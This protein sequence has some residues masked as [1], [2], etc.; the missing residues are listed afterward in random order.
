MA[1]VETP[2]ESEVVSNGLTNE[3][4]TLGRANWFGFTLLGFLVLVLAVMMIQA[5]DKTIEN[6]K[7]AADTESTAHNLARSERESLIFVVSFERWLNGSITLRELQIRRAFLA[8]RL[9][10]SDVEGISNGTRASVGYMK[11]LRALDDYMKLAEPG[12]LSPD[13]QIDL[14]AKSESAL[15]NFVFETNKL[16]SIVSM[17]SDERINQLVRIANSNR[18]NSSGAIL[19]VLILVFTVAGSLLVVRLRYFRR[20]QFLIEHDRQKNEERDSVLRRVEHELQS[21]LEKERMDRSDQEWIDA[22]TRSI[23]S[24]FKS[25]LIPERVAELLGEELGRVLG[26][27]TVLSL[28]LDESHLSKFLTQWNQNPKIEFKES[29]L[30]QHGSDL[31]ALAS[32]IWRDKRVVTVN[33]S[34]LIDISHDPIPKFAEEAQQRLRSWVIAPVGYGPQ[35]LGLLCV[36][37]EE[38]ARVWSAAEVGLIKSVASESANAYINLR[39]FHQT[40]QVAENDATVA[41][42]IELDKAKN[43]LIE[44]MNHELRSPLTSIIGYVEMMIGDVDPGHQPDLAASLSVV[45]RNAHRLQDLIVNTKRIS[46]SEGEN[47]PLEISTVDIGNLLGDAVKSMQL[48]ADEGGVGMTLRLDSSSD[49]LLIDGDL[50]RLQQ[51]F[52]NLLSNAVKFTPREGKVTVVARRVHTDGDY[53]EVSVTDTGIGI[54][55][56]EFPNMF[57]RFFRASTATQASIPGFG[58]GLSLVHSIVTEHHGTITFD[59]VVGKGTVFTVTLPLRFMVVKPKTEPT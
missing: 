14:R 27:D 58:I 20:V 33:D 43:D 17:G 42:L 48:G 47:V 41:R 12:F 28:A 3:D 6:L 54:P 52:V 19:A 24:Q 34:R 35:V 31:F 16:V 44:N 53:V 18:A 21:R 32:R 40:M 46:E 56:E 50:S 2:T 15:K 37:M 10:V 9:E 55:P 8:R 25:T 23:S 57:K 1:L 39:I 4:F 38:D 51:V 7:I 45:Q 13:D 30:T 11:E 59:S 5:Q 29:Y 26:A 22:T 36:A 49:D